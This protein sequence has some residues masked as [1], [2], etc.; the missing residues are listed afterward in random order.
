[1]VST[2][3]GVQRIGWMSGFGTAD[4]DGNFRRGLVPG[5]AIVLLYVAPGRNDAGAGC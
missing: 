3:D 2:I 4:D 5:V 1:M